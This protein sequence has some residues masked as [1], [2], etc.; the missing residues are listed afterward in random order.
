[1]KTLNWLN[2]VEFVVEGIH[3]KCCVGDYTE[4]T[5]EDRFIL[6]KDRASLES[7]AAVLADIRPR[8]ALEFGIFQ[9]G[10][11]ALF[12]LWFDLEKFVGI[13]ICS[14]VGP[15][16]KFCRSHEAGRKIRAYYGVSQTDAARVTEI[17]KDEFGE[18]PIDLII[19]DASHLYR[20][21][22]R[23]FEIAFP[24]LRPGG[25]Y[26]IEDWGWAHW[27]GHDWPQGETALS[28]LIMEL[29]MLCASR[30]DLVSEVRVFPSFAFIH[31][32]ND[33]KP[34][35]EMRLGSLY[36]KRGIE[37]VGLRD[38]NVRGFTKLVKQKL[39]LST[40]RELERMK[41]RQR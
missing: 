5:N 16:D 13:D 31:K 35:S 15:F 4:K 17:A 23:A 26:V 10:S 11:A 22:R 25:I 30:P 28:M 14:S 6:L 19:D 39:K 7:Y 12:T 40:R 38:L 34:M 33:A 36:E 21:T 24:L 41:R 20:P 37:L 27:P 2:D 18:V 1:M 9:G 8:N 32:S 29:L 3:F